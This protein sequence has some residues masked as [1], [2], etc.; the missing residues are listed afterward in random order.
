MRA[1]DTGAPSL[2]ISQPRPAVP[3]RPRVRIAGQGL[4][5]FAAAQPIAGGRV[6]TAGYNVPAR[7]R[8]ASPIR[9]QVAALP[10]APPIIPGPLWRYD[11]GQLGARWRSP[12]YRPRSLSRL[13]CPGRRVARRGRQ[14]RPPIQI[15][16]RHQT[17]SAGYEPRGRAPRSAGFPVPARGGPVRCPCGNTPWRPANAPR[18]PRR[19]PCRPRRA[20]PR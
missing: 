20:M 4:E 18:R 10:T 1:T 14:H 17:G 2:P 5:A 3:A 7:R 12:G 15:N 6:A 19:I 9:C 11:A 16:R 8:Q 13:D